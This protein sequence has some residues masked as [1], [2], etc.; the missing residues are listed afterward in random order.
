MKQQIRAHDLRATFIMIALANGR[1]ESWVADRTGHRSSL[2]INRYRR[3]ARSV[4]ELGLGELTSLDDA[5]P[6]FTSKG[7]I[8]PGGN[9][10]DESAN[11]S[12]NGSRRVLQGRRKG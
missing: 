1:S 12:A 5:I 9:T 10:D 11:E 8:E 4:A 7:S 6:E 2:M 3:A